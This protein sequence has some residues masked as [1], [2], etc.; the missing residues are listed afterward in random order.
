[1]YSP[2]LTMSFRIALALFGLSI[3]S[4]SARDAVRTETVVVT[5]QIELVKTAPDAGAAAGCNVAVWLVPLAPANGIAEAAVP[6][7]AVPRVI[8]KHKTF[9]PRILVIQT[10]SAVEFPNLDPFFHN[11]FSLFDGKKFDLGLYEAGSSRAVRFDRPGVCYVFCNIHPEMSAV[12]VVVNTPYFGLTDRAG[13]IAVPDVPPG[14]YQVQVWHERSLP[15]QLKSLTR[16]VAI[17]NEAHSLGTL[18]VPENNR[19][20]MTHKNKYG[21]DYDPPAKSVYTHP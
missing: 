18:R 9:A 10:G 7:R 6:P 2:A 8:Q 1:M 3:G 4:Q 20:R 19:M 21:R 14:R 15:D 17:S 5:G 13:R 11:V 16:E 12:V